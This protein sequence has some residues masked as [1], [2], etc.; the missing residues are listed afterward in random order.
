MGG[1]S[2]VEILSNR[3]NILYAT[4]RR[5]FLLTSIKTEAYFD[6]ITKEKN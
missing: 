2:L 3:D 5:K 1:G 6:K 4:S